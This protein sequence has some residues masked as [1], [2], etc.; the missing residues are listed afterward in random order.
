M[1]N[2]SVDAFAMSGTDV[3]AG[4]F[5]I[6]AGGDAN[7]D[8]IAVFTPTPAELAKN[9]GFNA[10]KTT[11]IPTDWKALNFS[12]TDGKSTTRKEGKYAVQIA[13]AAGIT[14]TL[15]QTLA[16]SGVTGD[17]FTFSFWVRGASIPA[18]GLCQGQVILYSGSAKKLTKTI[19]CGSLSSAFKKKTLTFTSTS[20]YDKVVIKFTYGKAS[21]TVWFD[22]ASLIR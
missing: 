20:A 13:G 14:K 17:S 21:G 5:F 9:G 3:Y 12:A 8:F 7:A 11:K 6:D 19:P 10:Y 16:L 18:A 15:A 2:G 22:L 1:L 4:G